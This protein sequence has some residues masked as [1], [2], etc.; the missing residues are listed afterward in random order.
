MSFKFRRVGIASGLINWLTGSKYNQQKATQV[1]ENYVKNNFKLESVS[2]Y[3]ES[4]ASTVKVD[5]NIT[6][7][8]RNVLTFTN[9]KAEGFDVTQSADVK[10]ILKNMINSDNAQQ[11]SND[12]KTKFD[13]SL[14]N[15]QDKMTSD[16]GSLFESKGQN[17]I[18]NL[19]NDI[20]KRYESNFSKNNILQTFAN[21]SVNQN[22]ENIVTATDSEVGKFSLSQKVAADVVVESIIDSVSKQLLDNKDYTDITKSIINEQHKKDTGLEIGKSTQKAIEEG[23]KF[24]QTVTKEGSKVIQGAVTEGSKVAQGAIKEGSKVAQ[25]VVKAAENTAGSLI[26]TWKWIIIAIAIVIVIIIAGVTIF[27][28]RGGL[29][30]MTDAT[31]K[32]IGSL[33]PGMIPGYPSMIPGSS[34]MISGDKNG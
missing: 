16:F 24:G 4:L 22:L 27:L 9:T 25:T 32:I 34:S 15:F 6:Q 11:V 19:S 23:S 20:Q 7:N 18:N 12:M 33:P 31:T 30:Q 2:N 17:T 26:N 21:Y 1:V 14:K 28:M 5:T 3:L 10:T 8:M 13:E 29:G